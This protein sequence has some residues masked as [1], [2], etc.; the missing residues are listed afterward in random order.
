MLKQLLQHSH[1]KTS[2]CNV[3]FID[4]V[5]PMFGMWPPLENMKHI[6][7]ERENIGD[8][9]INIES[10]CQKPKEHYDKLFGVFFSCYMIKRTTFA[11]ITPFN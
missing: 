3:L 6:S 11:V 4:P 5:K 1:N 2:R 7:I 9:K 8:S 10:K